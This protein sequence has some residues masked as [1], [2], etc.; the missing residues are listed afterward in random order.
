MIRASNN[1]LNSFWIR[2]SSVGCTFIN[3]CWTHSF[4]WYHMLD[5]SRVICFKLIVRPHDHISVLLEEVYKG[6]S[7]LW[8]TTSTEIDILQI[9]FCSQ[10]NL[11][12]RPCGII[13]ISIKSSPVSDYVGHIT[14]PMI[15]HPLGWDFLYL[16]WLHLAMHFHV[17][18]YQLLHLWT[19]QFSPWSTIYVGHHKNV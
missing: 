18:P 14:S 1:F 8:C 16:H 19:H 7:L 12:V 5:D 17:H 11:F 15:P 6:L 2:G 9:F 4:Y 13:G 3:F 10:V